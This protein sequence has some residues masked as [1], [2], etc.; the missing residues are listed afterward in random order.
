MRYYKHSNGRLVPRK[1][2]G[3][4]QKATINMFGINDSE[5]AMKPMICGNCGYGKDTKWIP[6]LKTGICPKCENT[7]NH[8][9]GS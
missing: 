5:L 1:K 6:I 2:N 4:F 3:R 9:E 8:I 7:E